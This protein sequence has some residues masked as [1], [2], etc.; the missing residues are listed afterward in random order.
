MKRTL[1]FIYGTV[2]YLLAFFTLLYWFGFTGDLPL[3][4]TINTG[5]VTPLAGA[6]AINFALVLLF[7]LQHGIM[8][9]KSFKEKLTRIMPQAAERS[10]FVLFTALVLILIMWQWRP[11][12]I[13]L[14]QVENEIATAFIWGA[15]WG[16][17]ALL[18][19]S[20]FLINHFELFG[21]QQIFNNLRKKEVKPIAFKTPFLYKIVR[22]PM[23][24]GIVIAIWATPHMT[25][26]HLFYA[27][28]LT[29]YIYIGVYFEERDLVSNYKERYTEYKKQIPAVIPI[30]GKKYN[31]KSLA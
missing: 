26:G 10:T 18:L 30:I 28:I 23:M 11:I 22:H 27:I 1:V 7:G 2:S 15:F 9:R 5:E 4:K 29:T 21:L 17:W 12:P 13:T 31:N 19:L 8:A 6:L 14:W 3:P 25:V 20:T 24:L 16:G